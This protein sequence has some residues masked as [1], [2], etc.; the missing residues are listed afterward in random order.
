MNSILSEGTGRYRRNTIIVAFVLLL[1]WFVPGTD[2][3]GA[4]FFGVKI[5]ANDRRAELLVLGV[6]LLI[7]IYQV[8][9]FLFYAYLEFLKWTGTFKFPLW[10]FGALFRMGINPSRVERA[11]WKLLVVEGDPDR[12]ITF[13]YVIGSGVD[14]GPQHSI[15]KIEIADARQGIFIFVFI[16][17]L[18]PTALAE[19][20]VILT[21]WRITD[22][23]GLWC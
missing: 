1:I 4:G 16:D 12:S 5:A 8:G 10:G 3:S 21:V 14:I 22:L 11:D 15:G 18:I 7:L 6:L 9:L 19:W 17:L 23:L 20:A 13:K 2:F